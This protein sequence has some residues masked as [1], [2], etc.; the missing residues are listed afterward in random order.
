MT[1]DDAYEAAADAIRAG[2]T[3]RLQELLEGFPGLVG[4]STPLGSL[5]HVS[6]EVGN[7]RAARTLLGKGASSSTRV[8]LGGTALN[9]AAMYCRPELISLLLEAGSPLDVEAGQNPLLSAVAEGCLEAVKHLIAAGMDPHHTYLSEAGVIKNALSLAIENE[10]GEVAEFLVSIGCEVPEQLTTEEAI[11]DVLR[12]IEPSSAA[13]PL[14]TK[15]PSTAP[16]ELIGSLLSQLYGP[17]DSFVLQE[18]VPIHDRV[19]ISVSVV[20]PHDDHPYL[21]LFTTGMSD[22]AMTVPQGQEDFAHAELIMHLPGDWPHPRSIPID[23][24]MNWPVRWLRDF[25]YYPHLNDTWLGGRHTI[26][27]P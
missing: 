10:Q 2:Q 4:Y 11:T 22:Q 23:H 6:A 1:E 5:L 20:P 27:T 7:T 3:G 24:P 16:T 18:V 26:I 8:L 13:N 25:A 17:V 15:A 12:E 21:T 9:I 14:A 19:R